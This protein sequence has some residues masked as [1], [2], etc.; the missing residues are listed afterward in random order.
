VQ[1][2]FVISA[3]W[4][5]QFHEPVHIVTRLSTCGW[6][7]GDVNELGSF[8]GLGSD[9][10]VTSTPTPRSPGTYCWKTTSI[11]QTAYRTFTFATTKTDVWV[12]FGLFV[13]GTG[14]TGLDFVAFYDS[15]SALQGVVS[16]LYSDQLLRVY[17]NTSGGTLLG[18][19]ALA[20]TPDQWHTAEVRWQITSTT[21]GTV[22]VWVD[23][24][25]WLNLTSVDN[26]NTANANVQSVRV[27]A[28]SNLMPSGGSYLAIDD[29]AINDTAGSI[30]NGQIH[31]GRVVLLKPNGAGSNTN[32]TRGGTDSGAN[33]SQ[34]DELPPS[35]TDYVYSATAATRDTYA[36]EDVP[37]GSWTVNCCEVLALAQNSDTGTG[38]LG[39]TVKSGATTNEGTAQNLATGAQYVRQLYELDPNTSAAWTVANVSALEAGVT[40]R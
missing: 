23:D 6:E 24:T 29:L 10:V 32:L 11:S 34:L 19:S 5:Y 26:T 18:T 37:S 39:L 4:S 21:V 25:R 30:N 1:L 2:V 22:E 8:G 7:T 13:H 16:W 20:L 40:V 12:R 38:S 15:A 27:G 3:S 9:T 35:M 33:W 17:R 28:T 14:G 36:L 31:D